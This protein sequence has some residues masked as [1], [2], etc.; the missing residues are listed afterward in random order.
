MVA[1]ILS[2]LA[3][4]LSIGHGIRNY[5]Q[6]CVLQLVICVTARYI[7]SS[8]RGFKLYF[9]YHG[10]HIPSVKTQMYKDSVFYVDE[11]GQPGV[12]SI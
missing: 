9:R 4:F 11:L 2:E 3:P 8:L 1:R 7:Q 5:I 6:I 10:T 12:Q